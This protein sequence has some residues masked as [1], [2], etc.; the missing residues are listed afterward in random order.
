M[1][2]LRVIEGAGAAANDWMRQ[3]WP[4]LLAE[5][6]PFLGLAVRCLAATLPKDEAFALAK[7]WY[8]TAPSPQECMQSFG[9]LHHAGTIELIEHWWRAAPPN[10]A[11]LH[12]APIAA[13]SEMKWPDISRWLAS[14]RP[15]SL[16]A[17]GVLEQYAQHGLPPGY[18]RPLREEFCCSL[19][20]CRIQDPAPRASSAVA[21]LLASQAKL[22]EP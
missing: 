4:I 13:M 2:A 18:V 12:W 10:E 20:E 1:Q 3:L 15:L 11:T 16:I 8:A 14:G 7:K 22:S 6:H 17:L 5:Q 19:E 9:N 21:R